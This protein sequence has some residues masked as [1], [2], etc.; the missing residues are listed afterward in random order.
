MSVKVALVCSARVLFL[1]LAYISLCESFGIQI[2]AGG[3]QH[4]FFREVHSGYHVF[5]HF[6]ARETINVK[7]LNT[8]QHVIY[9]KSSIPQGSFNFEAKDDGSYQICLSVDPMRRQPTITKF[10]FLVVHPNVLDGKVATSGQADH[11]KQ[12][13]DQID[14]VSEQVLFKTNLY[15]DK[16]SV[17]DEILKSSIALAGRLVAMECVAALVGALF[18]VSYIR[19][20]LSASRSKTQRMV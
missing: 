1:I 17:T 6:V 19:R 3:M 18:Q 9:E 14:N 7:I 15:S 5:A 12:L 2:P 8:D 16:A 4:C 13:C 20:M 11:S 10:R